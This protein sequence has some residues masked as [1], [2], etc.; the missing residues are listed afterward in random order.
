MKVLALLTWATIRRFVRESRVVRSL[1][2][3]TFLGPVTVSLTLVAVALWRSP[4]RSATVPPDLDAAMEEALQ[5]DGWVLIE[6]PD[7]GSAVRQ[8]RSSLATDGHQ[9]WS[10]TGP[11][12]TLSL[13]YVVREVR[14]SG[15]RMRPV[16]VLPAHRDV[17][18]MGGHGLRPL[19]FLYV[20]YAMVFTMGSLARDNDASILDVERSLPI[21]EW[22]PGLVRWVA[23]VTVLSSAWCVTVLLMVVM[24]D[25]YE[26]TG[27]LLRGI[28]S[29]A[30]A[31]A[32]GL[33]VIGG[34][35]LKQGF[36]SSFA[37]GAFVVAG[38][39]SIGLVTWRLEWL[40]LIGILGNGT[41][42]AAL[43]IGLSMGPPA[44][45]FHAWRVRAT[46]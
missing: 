9:V 15:W 25:A 12:S 22:A 2:W 32:V 13:E 46:S 26:P 11:N 1:V 45:L 30:A 43:V 10:S 23:T 17:Q 18:V 41:G 4:Q 19:A 39:V 21:P 27:H 31:A 5:D 40:P 8:G 6:D 44:A 29:I 35:G 37:T 24:M 42:P 7:P 3:P 16:R 20:L 38:L 36:S 34:S 14:G 28:G 33:A